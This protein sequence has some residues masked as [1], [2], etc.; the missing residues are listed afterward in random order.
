MKNA[1]ARIAGKLGLATVEQIKTRDRKIASLEQHLV[2]LQCEIGG[3]EQGLSN[4]ETD[5]PA[6]DSEQI[7][8]D[9]L[10]AI[11]DVSEFV[12]PF[13]LDLDGVIGG[14]DLDEHIDTDAVAR[15]VLDHISKILAR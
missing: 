9:G 1:I 2:D 13:A 10:D 5:G 7:V 3:L 14:L 11:G 15:E 4:L 6:I 12:D 8:R